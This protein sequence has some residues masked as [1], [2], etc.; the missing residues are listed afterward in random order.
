LQVAE[1]QQSTNDI[2]A[3]P[4]STNDI[5]EP[6]KTPEQSSFNLE[7][8]LST[9]FERI[10]PNIE[11]PSPAPTIEIEPPHSSPGQSLQGSWADLSSIS[12]SS[13][14]GQALSAT[15]AQTLQKA[16]SEIEECKRLLL[17]A[18]RSQ[19]ADCQLG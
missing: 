7:T 12:T 13:A 8:P 17:L 1:T 11:V 14:E 2:T 15:Q 9:N 6:A 16:L 4:Q 10:E 18:R 5:V 3:L 19:E